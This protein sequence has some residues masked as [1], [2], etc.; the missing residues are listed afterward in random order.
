MIEVTKEI[1]FV[2]PSR[3]RPEK[4]LEM[5]NSVID[6]AASPE[7]IE[8][9][10]YLDNDET[11]NYGMFNNIATI[12]RGERVFMGK[13]FSSCIENASGKTIVI[14]NDDVIVRTEKWD[15]ILY[16]KLNLYDDDIFLFYPNDLN[17][18]ENLCTFPIFSKEFFLKF[19]DILPDDLNLIDLH[20]RDLF[21]QL[22]GLGADRIQYLHNIVFEHLHHTLGKSN[23]DA[24]YTDRNRF[25]NDDLFILY[26]EL[27]FNLS[28]EI[29]SIINNKLIPNKILKTKLMESK[30]SSIRYFKESL[31]M[32]WNNNAPLLYR[33]KLWFYMLARRVY[34]IFIYRFHAP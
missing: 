10:I 20:M 18:G 21:M 23:L 32:F 22:K 28:I 34:N 3:G 7:L 16:E 11:S 33:Y 29:D 25:G 8:F 15:D 27:R 9:V 30:M 2:I 13:M 31:W 14:C 24:T 4:L 19:P 5:V 1:S 17:K 26:A 6:C 12:T